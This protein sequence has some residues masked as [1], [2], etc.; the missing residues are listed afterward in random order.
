MLNCALLWVKL[1]PKFKLFTNY[2]ISI[3]PQIFTNPQNWYLLT[4]MYPQYCLEK[5]SKADLSEENNNIITRIRHSYLDINYLELKS[6]N[7]F[8]SP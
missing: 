7:Q 1:N 3:K 8:P 6:R 4:L 2:R 5:I